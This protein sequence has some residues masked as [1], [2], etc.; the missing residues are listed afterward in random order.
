M[1]PQ[2]LRHIREQGSRESPRHRGHMDY[3][4]SY[5]RNINRFIRVRL[6][7]CN[8]KSIAG[9]LN[10]RSPAARRFAMVSLYTDNRQAASV[11]AVF[12]STGSHAIWTQFKVVAEAFTFTS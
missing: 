4:N 3:C 7:F 1:E 9:T 6:F 2:R 12:A 11:T 10:C 5:Q 8:R